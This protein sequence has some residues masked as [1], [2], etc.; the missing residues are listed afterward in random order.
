LDYGSGRGHLKQAIV[1]L[2]RPAYTIKEYDP[3]ILAISELPQEPVD[4]VACTDVLE[5]IEPECLQGV[6]DHIASLSKRAAFLVV[7]TVKAS[8]H[9]PD[10]RNAHLI[11]R[12]A[13]WWLRIF[14][15]H[16]RINLMREK[17]TE[18]YCICVPR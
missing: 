9:L 12:P 2:S 17:A 16:W 10:G 14:A 11:I 13:W 8:K 1:Q 18:F 7:S 4:A 15:D 6:I 3:A 5:H